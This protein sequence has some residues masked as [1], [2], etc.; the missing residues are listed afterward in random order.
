MSTP[1]LDLEAI[2]ER[3]HL[4]TDGDAVFV[5]SEVPALLDEVTRLRSQRDMLAATLETRAE[6]EMEMLK[7][8]AKENDE[9]RGEVER[10]RAESER[11][12]ELRIEDRSQ[13]ALE[14]KTAENLRSQLAEAR[15]QIA[16]YERDNRIISE[17]ITEQDVEDTRYPKT[18]QDSE[19]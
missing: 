14:C 3:L 4:T 13:A 5:L 6:R 15:E 17:G 19:R 16:T 2:R 9:L 8:V 12:H 1:E 18:F 10:L 11:L 7:G